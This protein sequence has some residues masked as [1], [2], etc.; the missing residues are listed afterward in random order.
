MRGFH[1]QAICASVLLA[2]MCAAAAQPTKPKPADKAPDFTPAKTPLPQPDASL[3]ICTPFKDVKLTKDKPGN[4]SSSSAVLREDPKTHACDLLVECPPGYV[5]GPHWHSANV[6]HTIIRGTYTMAGSSALAA[7]PVDLGPGSF[8]YTPGREVHEAHVTGSEPVLMLVT[9]DG[10]RDTKMVG[11]D[12][13]PPK[14][15]GETN[16]EMRE[17]LLCIPASQIK[18]QPL[19]PGSPGQMAILH[20]NPSTHATQAMLRIPGEMYIPRHWHPGSEALTVLAGSF[21]AVRKG[22]KTSLDTGSY[23]WNPAKLVHNAFIGTGGATLLVTTDGSWDANWIEN[24]TTAADPQE[25][26]E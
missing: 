6:T 25:H 19:S 7:T 3:V 15:F 22:T 13:D 14:A 9:F 8:N 5:I 10:A 24:P 1:L 20:E 23:N 21:S 26:K 17:K 11:A 4:T 2:G 12:G 16:P 18:W